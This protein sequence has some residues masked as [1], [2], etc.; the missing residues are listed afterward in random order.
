MSS[1]ATP[2]L[3][4]TVACQRHTHKRT[5]YLTA[6]PP[7]DPS[8]FGV[9]PIDTA[10]ARTFIETHHYSGTFPVEIGSYGL[11]EFETQRPSRPRRRGGLLDSRQHASR[12]NGPP[13]TWTDGLRPRPLHPKRPHPRQCRD[14]VSDTGLSGATP[15]QDAR[16]RANAALSVQHLLLGPLPSRELRPHHLSRPCR[17]RL[18]GEEFLLHG[19][20]P[21]PLALPTRI[22]PSLRTARYPSFAP[23]TTTPATVY[24]R[25]REHGAPA[26]KLAESRRLL[27][28]ARPDRRTVPTSSA[29]RQSPLRAFA[30]VPKPAP[31]DPRHLSAPPI[32]EAH[33]SASGRGRASRRPELG[34]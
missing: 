32:P 4:L 7:F 6:R 12:A 19:P 28:R 8:R 18:P 20:L 31:E 34:R 22:Q 10:D 11:F 17:H 23:T 25:L 16:R 14:L 33:R 30:F 1:L 26:L 2:W 29:S 13:R 24:A 21:R 15:G 9:E 5:T 27:S 3:D